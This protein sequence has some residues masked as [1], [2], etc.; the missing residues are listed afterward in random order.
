VPGQ[1]PS[2]NHM[3]ERRRGG[4]Q[5]RKKPGIE[6]FQADVTRLVRYGRPSGWHPPEGYLRIGYHFLLKRDVDA[7]NAIKVIEDGIAEAL[8]EGIDPPRCC[9]AFDTRFLPYTIAKSVGVSDPHTV[10][11]IGFVTEYDGAD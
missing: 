3:Y 4:E 11:L 10:L 8:C 6:A 2:G 9:R 7:T 5:L 1:P